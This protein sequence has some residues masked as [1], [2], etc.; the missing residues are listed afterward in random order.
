MLIK[1]WTYNHV[2]GNISD[3]HVG[4]R[5]SIWPPN[6]IN[7]MGSPVPQNQTQRKLWE[8]W[9]KLCKSYDEFSVE[10]IWH[11]GDGMQGQNHRDLGLGLVTTNMWEQRKAFAMVLTPMVCGTENFDPSI[12]EPPDPKTLSLEWWDIPPMGKDF[13][14]KFMANNKAESGVVVNSAEMRHKMAIAWKKKMLNEW[15]PK[16]MKEHYTVWLPH[17]NPGAWPALKRM[18]DDKAKAWLLKHKKRT[19]RAIGGTPY[20]QGASPGQYPEQVVVEEMLGGHYYGAIMIAQFSDSARRFMI[21]H[22]EG[23]AFMYPETQAG[24]ELLTLGEWEAIEKEYGH[25]DAFICGHLH[26]APMHIEKYGQHFMR[27][28]CWQIWSGSRF[29]FNP[30]GRKQPKCNAG[31]LMLDDHDRIR[32]I[33]FDYKPMPKVWDTTTVIDPANEGIGRKVA[34]EGTK[35]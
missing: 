3:T 15:L 21:T 35:K 34:S 17:I 20:H 9:M 2:V 4:C 10:E 14:K 32:Y 19:I 12:W 28:G 16:I 5:Y 11:A 7:F 24:R 33:S 1:T 8:Y 31:I 26:H 25:I 18:I 29:G 6:F 23:G 13:V 22:G 27:T 30:Y